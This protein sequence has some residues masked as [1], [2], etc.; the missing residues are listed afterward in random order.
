MQIRYRKCFF[1]RQNWL[2]L[3]QTI[4]FIILIIGLRNTIPVRRWL[5]I[6]VGVMIL[7][8]V[9][10]L[11]KS[12]KKLF[13]NTITK[14]VVWTEVTHF[15]VFTLI[16]FF[17]LAASDMV[18]ARAIGKLFDPF[19][20]FSNVLIY[21]AILLLFR[22]IFNKNGIAILFVSTFLFVFN[23]ASYYVFSFR[24]MP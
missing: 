10:V 17:I 24:R 20:V 23:L 9:Y 8:V 21:L 7:F 2:L 1:D 5:Y 12:M 6:S 16:A 22:A 19:R 13:E 4:V 11:R 3:F 14:G 15:V 18:N